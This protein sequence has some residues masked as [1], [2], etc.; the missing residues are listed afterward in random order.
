MQLQDKPA[1]LN[2]WAKIIVAVAIPLFAVAVTYGMLSA[3]VGHND[4]AIEALV[5]IP[6]RLSAVEAQI[7]ICLQRSN[8]RK[9]R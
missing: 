9:G 6:E 8:D 4:K 1:R 3:N 2:G 5:D 7:A